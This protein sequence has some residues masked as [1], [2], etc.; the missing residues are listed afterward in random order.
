M[1]DGGIATPGNALPLYEMY[2]NIDLDV[3]TLS[4]E[5]LGARE[6]GHLRFFSRSNRDAWH[7]VADWFD[8]Q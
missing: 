2:P 1:G 6:L 5:A 7:I 4:P 8:Q 3:E